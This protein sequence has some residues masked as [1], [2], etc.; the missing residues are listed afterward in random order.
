MKPDNSTEDTSW[1]PE[2]P[3]PRTVEEKYYDQ[4]VAAS[5]D[6]LGMQHLLSHDDQA[7][8]AMNALATL[9]VN[10]NS[11]KAYSETKPPI[12]LYSGRVYFGDS[13][14]LFADP[15]LN[16]AKQAHYLNMACAALLSNAPVLKKG[17]GFLI[18]AGIGIG[19]LRIRILEHYGEKR[20]LMI[21]RSM[22]NA[23]R[24]EESQQWIGGAIAKEIPA[25]PVERYRVAYSVP[26]KTNAKV[27]AINWVKLAS[28]NCERS[29][30][31]SFCDDLKNST[32]SE[33]SAEQKVVNTIS[34]VE[35]MCPSKLF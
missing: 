27:D 14:Y 12:H 25:D 34:F 23:H 1:P 21:G 31:Q 28:E 29:V 10:T 32:P 19:N 6:L 22:A 11:P 24:I 26:M 30:L 17:A 33:S 15:D 9:I 5:V 20:E 35:A 13:V 18:R 8:S 16:I 7:V 4:I 3:K 2:L